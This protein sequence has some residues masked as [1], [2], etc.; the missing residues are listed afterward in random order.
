MAEDSDYSV[1]RVEYEVAPG[2]KLLIT[3]EPADLIIPST[4]LVLDFAFR[5]T[6]SET[7]IMESHNSRKLKIQSYMAPT[8]MIWEA[9]L[10]DCVSGSFCTAINSLYRALVV[11]EE[12]VVL[13][14]FISFY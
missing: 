5:S 9:T 2:L 4:H 12:G 13:V 11:Y 7:E 1:D 14:S 10:I 3:W 6:E 8:F